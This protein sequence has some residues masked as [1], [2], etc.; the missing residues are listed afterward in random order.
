MII[1]INII[2]ITAECTKSYIEIQKNVFDHK[3]GAGSPSWL[4]VRRAIYKTALITYNTVKT[5]QLSYLR[6]LLCYH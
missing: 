6:D 3:L 5:G 4:P 2:I 1:I